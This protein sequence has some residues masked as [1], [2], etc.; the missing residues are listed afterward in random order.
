VFLI[1]SSVGCKNLR[2][3]AQPGDVFL[4][5]SARPY[6]KN[7]LHGQQTVSSFIANLHAILTIFYAKTMGLSPLL[8]TYSAALRQ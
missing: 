2:H 7:V 8:R 1:R 5:T 6:Q 4:T 3:E